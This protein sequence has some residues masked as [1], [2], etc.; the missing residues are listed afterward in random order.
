MDLSSEDSLRLNVLLHQ[1]VEAIRIDDSKMV[2]YGLSPRGEA[3]VPLNPNCRDEQYI[4]KVKEVISSHILGS[5]G[6]YPIFLRRWTRMGQAKDD[7][8]ERLLKLGEPEAVVAVVHAAGL[9]DELARRAWWAMPNSDNA[10]RMLEKQSVVEGQMGRTL[11]SFLVEFLPFEE[12]PKNMLESVRLVLQ[13]GLID[14]A[15]RDSLWSRGQRKNAFY[16]GFLKMLPDTLPE[17]TAAHPEYESLKA[18]LTDLAD[19]DQRV[20]RQLL[21]VLSPAGQ[22]YIKTAMTVFKKPANQDVVVALLEAIESYFTTVCPAAPSSSDMN[23][24]VTQA[25]QA[26][27]DKSIPEIKEVL[28]MA[29]ETEALLQS[30]LA[31][32][33]VGVHLVNPIFSRTDAIGTVM[34]RKLEPVT[35]PIL[36]LLRTLSGKRA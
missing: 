10:R 29:P 16:V 23:E 3:Q 9:T 18:R 2:V 5:P 14:E 22:A 7:S 21:R 34:R 26:C 27:T 36:D 1:D 28:E 33:W 15:T 35:V 25:S 31:L 32:S 30:M 13:P 20:S 11:A 6:G 24:L 12:D 8:L 19:A 17:Q 4:K